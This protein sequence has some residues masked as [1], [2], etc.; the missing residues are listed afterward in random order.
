MPIVIYK[1]FSSKSLLLYPL[2]RDEAMLSVMVHRWELQ[3]RIGCSSWPASSLCYF[4]IKPILKAAI[5]QKN[6]SVRKQS[7]RQ[8]T[9]HRWCQHHSVSKPAGTH[10]WLGWGSSP[11]NTCWGRFPAYSGL[12]ATNL[13]SFQTGNLWLTDRHLFL[14]MASSSSRWKCNRLQPPAIATAFTAQLLTH[15]PS[16]LWTVQLRQRL[17]PRSIVIVYYNLWALHHTGYFELCKKCLGF[18]LFCLSLPPHK[19]AGSLFQ[20]TSSPAQC[21]PAR[22]VWYTLSQLHPTS[23]SWPGARPKT[24]H[25]SSVAQCDLNNW[26]HLICFLH[27]SKETVFHFMRSQVRETW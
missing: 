1:D 15:V 9:G 7:T 8:P 17:L 12:R 27:G 10:A 2:R 6:L 3:A 13:I 25:F 21:L 11:Q 4:G 18:A 20:T 26:S 16:K 24:F 19:Q 14:G 23:H 5:T 22:T